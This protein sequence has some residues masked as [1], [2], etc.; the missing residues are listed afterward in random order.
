MMKN[1]IDAVINFFDPKA[2]LLRAQS[3]LAHEMVERKYDAASK[4]R[5]NNGWWRRNTS[6][7]QEVSAASRTL[8][9]TG[10]ELCRNN[11]LAAR[12]KRV[13]ANNA[14][15]AGIQADVGEKAQDNWDNWAESTDCDF[16]KQFC[17]KNLISSR[18]VKSSELLF[19]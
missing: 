19:C 11:P 15:G 4:G 6:A 8:S 3:R 2:G 18:G 16:S 9:A 14:V 5:R 1:P 13:W 10:Q 7:A 17:T 12:M